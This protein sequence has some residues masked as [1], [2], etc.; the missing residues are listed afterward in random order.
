MNGVSYTR[1]AQLLTN[2]QVRGE[3]PRLSATGWDFLLRSADQQ[4]ESQRY[5]SAQNMVTPTEDVVSMQ[6]FNTRLQPIEATSGYGYFVR[7]MWLAPDLE[8]QYRE[9]ID[10]L[11]QCADEE[12]IQISD[13]SLKDIRSFVTTLARAGKLGIFL[14]DNG[15]FRT[16]QK[17]A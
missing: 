5:S 9:R 17:Q 6:N 12:G 11:V 7:V 15:H 2:L 13:S 16:I 4:S 14:L 10:E 1:S 3:D 8:S